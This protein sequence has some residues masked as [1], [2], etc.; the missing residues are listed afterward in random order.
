MPSGSGSK[1]FGREGRREWE[2][3]SPSEAVI[4]PR[5]PVRVIGLAGMARGPH[6]HE[7]VIVPRHPYLC[8]V[9]KSHFLL[10]V[11]FGFIFIFIFFN[12]PLLWGWKHQLPDMWWGRSSLPQ[13]HSSDLF[14][15]LLFFPVKNWNIVKSWVF[16]FILR[17]NIIF[18]LNLIILEIISSINVLLI[19]NLIK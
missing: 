18:V 13:P 2:W 17:P 1:I 4:G 11:Y 9:P 7:A 15:L 3:K 5:K 19:I 8:R 12:L 6:P 16:V 14:F 10:P